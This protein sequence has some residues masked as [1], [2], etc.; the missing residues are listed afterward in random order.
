MNKFILAA[1]LLAVS[2]FS[3]LGQDSFTSIVGAGYGTSDNNDFYNTSGSYFLSQVD[4]TKGPFGEAVFLNR[5]NV[6]RAGL[7]R[8]DSDVQGNSF[9]SNFWNLGGTYHL[10]TTGFFIN[11]DAAHANR[12]IGGNSESY[13]LGAGY[14]LSDDWFVTIDTM[15]DK[16]FKYE[17]MTVGTKKLIDLGDDSFISL[18]ARVTNKNYTYN[19]G[20]DYYFT[21]RF[22]IG[23]AHTW[24]DDVDA[25][26][27]SINANWF[28]T[29]AISVS[30]GIVKLDKGAS[31]DNQFNFGASARF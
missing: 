16:D 28:I 24:Y 15:H 1:S 30:L 12:S 19:I 2:S 11:I 27:S 20:A 10:N 5:A 6:L 9:A 29:D 7:S 21:K 4:S 22:S 8:S 3:A 25:D 26:T 17:N 14:Y 13:T 31:T 18:N 23:L